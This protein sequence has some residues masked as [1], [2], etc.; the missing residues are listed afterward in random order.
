M[1]ERTV[2]RQRACP[3]HSAAVSNVARCR[4]NPAKA[5]M[6]ARSIVLMPLVSPS[7]ALCPG[8]RQQ[9]ERMLQATLV[10]LDL[11]RKDAAVSEVSA[12]CLVVLLYIEPVKHAVQ[13]LLCAPAGWG[14]VRD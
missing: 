11:K 2:R 14:R 8:D 4:A 3:A 5:R 1:S 7:S 12:K 13:M 9:K 6:P 10:Q